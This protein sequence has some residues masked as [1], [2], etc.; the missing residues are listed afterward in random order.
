[1]QQLDERRIPEI[2]AQWESGKTSAIALFQQFGID[3]ATL[4]RWRKERATPPRSDI[5]ER[6]ASASRPDIAD[7]ST[8]E[9]DPHSRK[10]RVSYDQNQ[11]KR[12]LAEW[13]STG[14]AALEICGKYGISK[15]T[16]Y[17]WRNRLAES[18]VADR[19]RSPAIAAESR[20]EAEPKRG[21]VPNSAQADES[22]AQSSQ[23]RALASPIEDRLQEIVSQA[24]QGVAASI[25]QGV[26]DK[27]EWLAKEVAVAVRKDMAERLLSR[28]DRPK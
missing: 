4:S 11:I 5:E 18:T 17:R 6:A 20:R 27:L 13:Q 26:R 21:P 22:K 19:G 2:L 24:A 23:A 12:I 1:M 16:L 8:D 25:S 7:V 15:M 28:L 3:A 14:A 10:P 9:K